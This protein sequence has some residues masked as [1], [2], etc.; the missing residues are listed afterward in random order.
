MYDSVMQGVCNAWLKW[1]PSYWMGNACN[2]FY[3]WYSYFCDGFTEKAVQ[4]VC[5]RSS[6][7]I[8]SVWYWRDKSVLCAKCGESFP[9][10]SASIQIFFDAL[11]SSQIVPTCRIALLLQVSFLGRIALE[12]ASETRIRLQWDDS[13]LNHRWKLFMWHNMYNCIDVKHELGLHSRKPWNWI[14]LHWPA[15]AAAFLFFVGCANFAMLEAGAKDVDAWGL[16]RLGFTSG[17]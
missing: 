9:W 16:E 4:W 10:Y 2:F 15:A 3:G 8:W 6:A 12:S 11:L 7:E 5:W 1:L 17:E 13:V 14:A